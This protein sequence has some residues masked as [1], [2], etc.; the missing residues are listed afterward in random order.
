MAFFE[1]GFLCR[2]HDFKTTNAVEAENHLKNMDH[3]A[4]F[5]KNGR[6]RHCSQKNLYFNNVRYIGLPQ[7]YDLICEN[8]SIKLGI[9]ANAFT[10]PLK[11]FNIVE[12]NNNQ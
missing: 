8:C 2:K 12:N 6:C 3:F 4:T 9:P 11:A 5:G 10:D 1:G 7:L